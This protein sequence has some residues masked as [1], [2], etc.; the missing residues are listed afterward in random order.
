MWLDSAIGFQWGELVILFLDNCHHLRMAARYQQLSPAFLADAVARL[1]RA[2]RLGDAT[3]ASSA[4]APQSPVS[5]QQ[6]QL[7]LTRSRP[8]RIARFCRF[9]L[10]RRY[11]NSDTERGALRISLTRFGVPLGTILNPIASAR[12]FV[13]RFGSSPCN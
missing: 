7:R 10:P 5:E 1:D 12:A 8:A 2:C 6:P 9:A 11:Q 13:L 4:F 3:S